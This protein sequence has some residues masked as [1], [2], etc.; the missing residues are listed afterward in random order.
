[1]GV[2]VGVRGV[3]GT[4]GS[5]PTGRDHVCSDVDI[6]SKQAVH[7]PAACCPCNCCCC[8]TCCCRAKLEARGWSVPASVST[9]PIPG[10]NMP[11]DGDY[12]TL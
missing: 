3:R 1:M 4:R 8:H 7:C 5:V 6:S 12:R 11:L 9:V 2:G 10:V